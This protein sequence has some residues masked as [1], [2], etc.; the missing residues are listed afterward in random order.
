V[1]AGEES[2]SM[3]EFL[4]G[5][6]RAVT[7]SFDLP[8]PI[9]EV[10][11]YQ[12]A[13]QEQIANLR[14]LFPNR[15]YLG[16]DARPGPGVDEVA[17]VEAMPY[18]EA[19]FGTVITMNTFEHVPRFWRAFDEIYR[20]LRPDGALFITCPF[21]FHIHEFPSDYWRF[22]PQAYR[23]LLQDY[24]TQIVGWQG[25]AKRP[26]NVWALA[27]REE[28]PL[29]RPAQFNRY[30]RLVQRYARQPLSWRK[31][32]RYHVGRLICGRGPFAPYLD[33]ERWETE[34]RTPSLT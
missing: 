6:A 5:V 16:I 10:G 13:G 14:S 32:W 20:V 31:K 7:E 9:L 3:N 23:I 22:T 11:A 30:R 29:V 12:V 2:A 33:Q 4:N 26:A 17:D 1:S 19:S 8:G 28:A 18:A 24:P 27:F 21:Y 34:C 15:P 25:P